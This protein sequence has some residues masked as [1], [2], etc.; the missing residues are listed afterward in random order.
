MDPDKGD[1][2]VLSV[3]VKIFFDVH[4]KVNTCIFSKIH[5][6]WEVFFS[7]KEM[8]SSNF[9]IIVQSKFPTESSLSLS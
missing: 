5:I 8:L 9:Y 4:L 3:Q 7:K 2:K 6:G 1:N